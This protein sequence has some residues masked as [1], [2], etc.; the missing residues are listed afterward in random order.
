S[1]KPCGILRGRACGGLFDERS[2]DENVRL[3]PLARLHPLDQIVAPGAETVHPTFDRVD[4][5]AEAFRTKRAAP[6]VVSDRPQRGFEPSRP[7]FLTVEQDAVQR[8]VAV[9]ENVRFNGYGFAQDPFDRKPAAIDFRPNCFNGNSSS[10]VQ[11]PYRTPIPVVAYLTGDATFRTECYS[12][13]VLS[14]FSI[15]RARILPGRKMA[16][17]D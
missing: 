17:V 3:R 4:M 16:R 5:Q 8:I 12:P 10:S 6:A 15:A 11:H 1:G 7:V 13:I 9:G 14:G 2:A